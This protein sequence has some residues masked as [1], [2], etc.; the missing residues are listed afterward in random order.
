M[1]RP[2]KCT[3]ETTAKMVEALKKGAYVELA[4]KYAR[5][6]KTTHYSWMRMGEKGDPKYRDYYEQITAADSYGG[7][8]ALETI[9]AAAANGTW[10]AAAWLLERRHGYVKPEWKPREEPREDT[11]APKTVEELEDRLAADVPAVVLERAAKKAR[12]A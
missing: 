4:I 8:Q 2:C 12:A 6:S 1:G 10:Q 5:I 3:P 7:L 9:N 11:T